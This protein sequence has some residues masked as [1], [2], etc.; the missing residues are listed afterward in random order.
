[1]EFWDQKNTTTNVLEVVKQIV[2]FWS[3]EKIKFRKNQKYY[4]QVNLQLNIEKATN[5]LKWQP[6]YKISES[7]KLQLTG[8]KGF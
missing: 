1:M 5:I 6:K 3:K 7:I 4:E 8:I 2:K